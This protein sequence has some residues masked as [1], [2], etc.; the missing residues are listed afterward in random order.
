M[1]GYTVYGMFDDATPRASTRFNGNAEA[2]SSAAAI[3]GIKLHG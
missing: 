3:V 2:S 1:Y